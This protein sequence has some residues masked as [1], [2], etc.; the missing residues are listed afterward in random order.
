MCTKAFAEGSLPPGSLI[1]L[2]F[3]GIEAVNG[4]YIKGTALWLLTCGQMSTRP[5]ESN[6]SP[7]H[8]ADPRP[9]DVYVSVAGVYSRP[10][11]R[12]SRIPEGH[13]SFPSCLLVASRAR[14][15]RIASLLGHLDSTLSL[16]LKA[17]TKQETST[18]PEL[19]QASSLDEGCDRYRLE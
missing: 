12:V 7:R 18:A 11:D 16:T 10:C 6:L 1:V 4:S 5:M 8:P 2:D 9:Y 13:E 14:S 17:L 15:S 19:Y 3:S